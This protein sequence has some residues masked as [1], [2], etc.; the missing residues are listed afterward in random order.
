MNIDAKVGDFYQSEP[1]PVASVFKMALISRNEGFH[2]IQERI[3]TGKEGG[4][5]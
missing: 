4:E 1:V 3:E 2:D 5:R